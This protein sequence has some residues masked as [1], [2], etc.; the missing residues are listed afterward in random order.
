[1][2]VKTRRRLAGAARE[3]NRQV[4]LSTQP[5]LALGRLARPSPAA[6]AA[7]PAA[8]PVGTAALRRA[9]SSPMSLRGSAWRSPAV[10]L[11]NAVHRPRLLHLL[12]RAD[13]VPFL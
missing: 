5:R 8:G 12:A 2:S 11:R 13:R 6:R 4:S 9:S 1:M 3:I 10:A 7:G